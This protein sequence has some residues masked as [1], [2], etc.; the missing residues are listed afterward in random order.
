VRANYADARAGPSAGSRALPSESAPAASKCVE[1]EAWSTILQAA[2]SGGARMC[3]EEATDRSVARVRGLTGTWRDVESYSGVSR[4]TRE[5]ACWRSAR[6]ERK[7][8]D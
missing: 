3:G 2:V 5:S 1:A 4:A 7:G 6:D 8:S